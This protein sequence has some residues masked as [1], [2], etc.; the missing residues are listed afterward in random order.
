MNSNDQRTMV[1]IIFEGGHVLEMESI[2][3]VKFVKY[4]DD[5]DLVNRIIV[6]E[7]NIHDEE[8]PKEF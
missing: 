5:W 2:T 3:M 1:K 7:K 4:F 8:S 6:R